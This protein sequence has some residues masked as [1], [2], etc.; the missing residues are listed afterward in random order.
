M[1]CPTVAVAVSGGVDSLCALLL[2]KQAGMNPVA[3]HGLF[4]PNASEPPSGLCRA[5]DTLHVP[6]H[7]IDVRTAFRQ[8]VI[9]PF[10]R[11]YAAGR[12]PNPCAL[13]NSSIKFGVLKDAALALGASCFATGHYSRLV[14]G[15]EGAEALPLI[16]AA[17]DITKDQSYFL[18]LVTRER[19]SHTL[20]PLSEYS[21]ARCRALVAAAGLE[22]PLPDE[23]QD[24]CFVAQSRGTSSA[25][26]YRDYLKE[27]WQELHIDLPAPGPA[28]LR[29]GDGSLRPIG[30]HDGLWRFTEGQ[31]RG[32]GL[33]HSSPLFVIAKE[34]NTN[35]LIVGPRSQLGIMSCI[36]AQVNVVLP[37]HLWPE[38]ILARLRYRQSPAT[39]HATLEAGRL[40]ID[41]TKKQFPT[42][43]GQIAAIY[44]T[45]GRLLAAGVIE[46]MQ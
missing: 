32:L 23:S 34:K 36:A 42:A 40:H 33:A 41:L 28:F 26:A 13:C 37:P 43:P 4:L 20:F 18:A 7:V 14:P 17:H 1:T 31:R 44:D 29:E 35:A 30:Q 25:K 10:A 19:L 21:K 11:E 6:L 9:I 46:S 22:V 5:C 38:K 39:A 16:C 27:Y 24:V 2:L 8:K 12:T 3:V 15:P 45:D